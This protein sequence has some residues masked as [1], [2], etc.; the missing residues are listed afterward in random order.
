[1]QQKACILLILWLPFSFS[2]SKQT[3]NNSTIALPDCPTKCGNVSV[4]Y[5]FGIGLDAGCSIGP[6]YDINCSKSFNPP[7]P[8]LSRTNGEIMDISETKIR[9]KSNGIA[10]RCY[11]QT[12]GITREFPT[13]YGIDDTSPFSFSNENKFIVVGCDDVSYM[14]KVATDNQFIYGNHT[15]VSSFNRCG[16]SF[17]GEQGRYRFHPSDVSDSNFEHRIVETVPMVFDW[18][19]GNQT[20]VEAQKSNLFACQENSICV[21]SD[22]GLGGYHCNCSKGYKGN[23][24]LRPGCQAMTLFVLL[25]F[26]TSMNARTIRVIHMESALILQVVISALAST[27]IL[28]IN[29]S[30]IAL[31]GCPTKCGNVS[32]PYPFGIGLD[33]GCSIGPWYDINCSKSFNPPKPF[34]SRTNGEIIDI[35]ETK[36]RVKSNGIAY[37][38]YNQTG[39][40]TREFP[41]VYGIDETSPFSFSNENK[42]IVVGC[43]DVSYMAKVATDNLISSCAA[44]CSKS[45]DLSDGS[46]SGIG[47]CQNS[48]PKGL[49]NYINFLNSY[50]NHTKVSSFN[51]CGYSFLGEQGRYRFHPSDVSDSNFEHRIVETVPMLRNPVYLLVRKIASVLILILVLEDITATAPRDTREIHISDQ[52]A[53]TI[54]NS[55]IALPGCPTKCGNVSVPYPFGIGLD[56]GCS[57]GPWYDINCSKSFNPPKP[58]LSR[59]NGE[60]IDISETKI[61]V[62]SNGI[63]YRCYNQTGGITREFPTVYGIDETSPFSFSNENKFIV[64]GC[65]D[66]SYM[67]KVATDNLISSCAA[68]C[69]KSSDLSDGSCSGI[70]CCQNSIP[71]G[72]KNYI[73]FLNSYG[74]HTKVSSFNRCGYSFLGEQGRYRKIASVLILI[75]VLEDITATAPRDTREIH[76]SD[77]VAKVVI[78]ALA[79]MVILVMAANLVLVALASVQIKHQCSQVKV[80]ASDCYYC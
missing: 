13:V 12:G 18:V 64:V 76:I 77:Q 33:A 42:F 63:A 79:S 54:N 17:L 50:G 40:I 8:F 65:D 34:L 73:N 69:S 6:W 10:Y 60:I 62:K 68:I 71:K 78:S 22:T 35:S 74:N 80:Q 24:Y 58:F 31:P 70:G 7:K 51:R 49:K 20:C 4:P 30:T 66:V 25:R 43:D 9:V 44:I 45:S 3:I 27:V 48:I 2:I 21:D 38:C 46:C 53:K 72:L 32:V 59:T 19:I 37:R 52:V 75:L 15:K 16:Y 23:P 57:I 67:A 11:N 55:T 36:I 61:R 26:Q 1:M 47:C 39:G 56:A 29:N 5:P 28:T 41:T 14:A